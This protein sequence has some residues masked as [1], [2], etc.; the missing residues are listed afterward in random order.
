MLYKFDIKMGDGDYIE[1]NKFYMR[2]SPYG[3]RHRITSWVLYALFFLLCMGAVAFNFG[4]TYMTAIAAIPIAVVTVLIIALDPIV[5][6]ALLR[7]FVYFQGKSGKPAYSPSAV[8]EF[9]ENVFTEQTKLNKTETS[10]EAIERV[11]V[12][13]S[14]VYIHV[15]SVMAYVIPLTAFDSPEQKSEFLAFIEGRGAE[16]TEYKKE[17]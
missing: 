9:Y 6:G 13:D 17:K 10:Y 16:I 5:S 8:L 1:Y 2:K 4:F 7:L 12:T 11:S 15:S 3:K 14:A